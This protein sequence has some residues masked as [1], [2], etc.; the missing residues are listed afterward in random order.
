MKNAT[1]LSLLS[2]VVLSAP[3]LAD[4]NNLT[5]KR[6]KSKCTGETCFQ[7]ADNL[8]VD[9]AQ[10][11]L[12]ASSTETVE[13]KVSGDVGTETMLVRGVSAKEENSKFKTS[14][15]YVTVTPQAIT[16]QNRADNGRVSERMDVDLLTGFYTYYAL[17][18]DGSMKDVP[19]GQPYA[20]YF[21][22][23][24]IGNGPAAAPT[25]VPLDPVPV[26]PPA[27]GTAPSPLTPTPAGPLVP[28]A[29]LPP[30]APV[31]APAAPVPGA[32]MAPGASVTPGSGATVT[33]HP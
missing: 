26:T 13:I 11:A 20:A 9:T 24:D 18:N 19:I 14:Y 21:G 2:L 22:W 7:I 27:P 15:E 30:G 25:P 17:H 4:T 28:G 32:A 3:A 8:K 10:K 12:P 16:L 33:T 1:R 31:T 23:C 6:Y 29:S 5:C